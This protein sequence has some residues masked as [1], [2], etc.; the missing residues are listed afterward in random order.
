MEKIPSYKKAKGSKGVSG[1]GTGISSAP[2][3]TRSGPGTVSPCGATD[4]RP[5]NSD[6][7]QSAR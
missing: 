2:K 7:S 6:R 5:A 3:T 1:A 4:S